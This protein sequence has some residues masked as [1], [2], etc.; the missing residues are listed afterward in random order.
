MLEPQTISIINDALKVH[1][2]GISASDWIAMLAFAFSV[3]TLFW[4]NRIRKKDLEIQRQEKK[5]DYIMRKWSAEYPHKLKL[6]TDFYDVLFRFVNYKGSPKQMPVSSGKDMTFVQVHVND[7]LEF[8]TE[9]NRIDEECKIL[10]SREIETKVHQVYEIMHDLI[11]AEIGPEHENMFGVINVI[12]NQKQSMVYKNMC[13]N[14]ENAQEQIR[15]LKLENN[16]R[17]KF[18]KALEF[19]RVN[20]VQN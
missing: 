13:Q 14:M 4:Q 3:G 16:L 18:I 8:Y 19:K 9:I 12:E 10:F 17:Q 2:Q 7:L 20:N 11:Y 15:Q 6:F 1:Q 5:A